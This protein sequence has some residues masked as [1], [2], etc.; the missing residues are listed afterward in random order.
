DLA[1]DLRL[2]LRGRDARVAHGDRDRR[3]LDVGPVLHAKLREADEARNRE[4][5][6]Q[7]DHRNRVAYRP[8]YEVHEPVSELTLTT[9][10]SLRNPAPL[11][12][13]ISPA[14]MPSSTSIWSVRTAPVSTRRRSTV[15]SLL[16]TNT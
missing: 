11:P 10:P 5:D 9:S 4:T 8:S 1:R 7:H 13:I 16:R 15:S 14:D 6:E 12:T 3:E 2:H